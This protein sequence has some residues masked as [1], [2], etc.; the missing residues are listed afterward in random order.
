VVD[1]AD[2]VAVQTVS[3]GRY[4]RFGPKA[5][6]LHRALAGKNAAVGCGDPLVKQTAE[7]SLE[8][9]PQGAAFVGRNGFSWTE[10]TLPRRRGR[11]KLAIT[12]D[13]CFIATKERGSE[14]CMPLGD[15]DRCVRALV[16]MSDLGRA[17]LDEFARTIELDLVFEGPI[18]EIR[19]QAGANA[20]LTLPA[21]DAPTSPGHVGL[22]D[23]GQTKVA[24]VTLADG[25][26]LFVS[27]SAGVFSTNV[28]RLAG[29]DEIDSLL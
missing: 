16:A 20:V 26:R 28:P 4:L 27:Q 14:E 22:F 21:P 1:A 8:S 3:G 11:I 6:T 29:P 5:A 23:D 25:R 19:E 10:R 15:G 9:G 7:M 17:K 24:A 12:G 13:V 18:E 2:G